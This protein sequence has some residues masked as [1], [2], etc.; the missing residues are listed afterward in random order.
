MLRVLHDEPM[1]WLDEGDDVV[2][3]AEQLQRTLEG[4]QDFLI[5][6]QIVGV[7]KSFAG[8]GYQ[9][10]VEHPLVDP[11]GAAMSLVAVVCGERPLEDRL[12]LVLRLRRGQVS[13]IRSP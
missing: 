13:H 2:P 1:L 12:E 7:A 11:F 3:L 9:L 10:G 6:G 8:D 4:P 5:R